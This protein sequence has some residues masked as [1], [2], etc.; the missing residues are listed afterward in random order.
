MGV[1]SIKPRERAGGNRVVFQSD[2]DFQRFT[3]NSEKSESELIY[4]PK[5]DE[6]LGGISLIRK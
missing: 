5:K 3:A 2:K 4:P 6:C 1:L